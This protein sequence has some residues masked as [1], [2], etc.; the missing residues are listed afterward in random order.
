M[1]QL[2]DH[3]L[4]G[5]Q[6][7]TSAVSGSF[8]APKKYEILIAR[9]SVLELLRPDEAT[10]R[11]ISICRSEAF[12]LIRSLLP[13]RQTGSN[14]D[15][16]AIGSDS[17]KLTILQYN[18]KAARFEIIHEE[19]FGKTGVRRVVPGE[20]LAIDPLGRAL[21]IAA[22]ER[23]K[24]VYILSRDH[25]GQLAIAS[26]LDAHKSNTVTYSICAVDVGDDNPT[27]ACLEASYEQNMGLPT[28][29]NGTPLMV[30]KE[31]VL[32]ELDLGLNTVTRKLALPAD[33]GATSVHRVPAGEKGP[34]GLIVCSQSSI[35][36]ITFD[37]NNPNAQGT[38]MTCPI[39][40]RFGTPEGSASMIVASAMH[41]Q[42][43][44]LFYFFQTEFGDVFRVSLPRVRVSASGDGADAMAAPPTSSFIATDLEVKYFDTIPVSISLCILRSGFLFAASEQGPSYLF[45]LT[46]LG[47]DDETTAVLTASTVREAESK[48]LSETDAMVYFAPRPNRNLEV[49]DEVD[50]IAPTMDFKLADLAGEP[51]P[52]MYV[53]CGQAHRAQLR[54]L[55]HGVS[56]AEAS[57]T[58]LDGNPAAIFSVRDTLS[59][60]APH[61]LIAIAY[62]SSTI[63][64]RVGESVEEI[65]DSGLIA[66]ATSLLVTRIALRPS[67]IGTAAP[68]ALVQVHPQ[69]IRTVFSAGRTADWRPPGRREVIRAGSNGRQL[70]VALAG[71]ELVVF[72]ADS[73]AGTGTLTEVGTK[74][75]R[76][77]IA[78]LALAPVLPGRARGAFLV[79]GGHDSTVRVFSVLPAT[80]LKQLSVQAVAATPTSIAIVSAVQWKPSSDETKEPAGWAVSSDECHLYVGLASGVLVRS[81]LDL[82]DGKLSNS[83]RRFLGARPPK[84]VLTTLN[85]VPAVV[86]ISS[87][88]WCFYERAVVTATASASNPG[89][90]AGSSLMQLPI[91]YE[92]LDTVADFMTQVYGEGMIG[93][94]GSSLRILVPQRLGELFSQTSINLDYTPRKLL[95]VTPAN[96]QSASASDSAM[97]AGS[98]SS[99]GADASKQEPA[100]PS[101]LVLETDDDALPVAERDSLL[102]SIREVAGLTIPDGL[103]EE[104]RVQAEEAL[105]QVVR[106]SGYPRG[107]KGK[108]A[109]QLRLVDP[110]TLET[111]H[112]VALPPAGSNIHE[113]STEAAFS[114][115]Y[116]KLGSDDQGYVVV[117]TARDLIQMPKRTVSGGSIHVFKVVEE[118]P[119]G[120]DKPIRRLELVHTTE[121]NDAVLAVCGFP[122]ERMLLAAVGTGVRLYEL[123]KTKLLLKS[124][125]RG[126]PSPV[127][128]LRVSQDRVFVSTAANGIYYC[129]YSAETTFV[130]PKG[131][132][133]IA[134]GVTGENIT[135]VR[136][137]DIVAHTVAPI[138]VTSMA[139]LDHDTV[140][141]SDRFGSVFV[142]RLSAEA[143]EAIM[144]DPTRKQSRNGRVT[145]RPPKEPYKL[146]D[147]AAYYVG[148]M[149]TSLEKGVFTRGGMECI[150]YTTISGRIG[151]L[152]AMP[153]R[154]DAEL[155]LHLEMYMRK[156][157]PSLVG[158]DH[159]AFRGYYVPVCNVI[160]GALCALYTS[161]PKEVRE[162]I[163]AQ[164]QRGSAQEVTRRI[165]EI[166]QLVL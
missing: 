132:T 98:G 35:Q 42:K 134:P 17:G 124:E 55:R 23:Q 69:G 90:F 25:D 140:A 41:V 125:T 152:I 39:P 74:D 1:M 66:E 109:S 5:S 165:E 86:A 43:D 8:S 145:D 150:V 76:N 83:R 70:A 78:S 28:L 160:D 62:K 161:L 84:L 163:A 119:D 67:D 4:L 65:S 18:P 104:E 53:A 33:P 96:P 80:M 51:A 3:C 47:D 38:T 102:A 103:S 36:Y 7:I 149:V 151:T 6:T 123:G 114:T 127:C 142:V 30:K 71:G 44:M 158:R 11:L 136:R 92:P 108:W 126:F 94:V 26:P 68:G 59:S 118:K 147:V 144:N 141:V 101:L 72:E 139:V 50:S 60:S 113:G 87:R 40:Q 111:Q 162:E 10:G 2:Y 157:V 115:C 95:T 52:Q 79:V 146:M 31:I 63:V 99:A 122:K 46:S 14:R 54:V 64:L 48:G 155:C 81:Q 58:D 29:S 133:P 166:I 154:E 61:S 153:T 16:V 77:D 57:A 19:T 100:R 15:Y 143:A 27:F 75:F 22:L 164:L 91:S 156:H 45:R 120:S 20:F 21:M 85:G 32:Y 88:T 24:F 110:V 34:G 112:I 82:T 107:G 159:M 9:S 105:Q 106:F 116:A 131:P 97:K 73:S 117:G 37:L 12:G 121:V 89:P 148:E 93:T 130:G 138:Y 56:V 128:G 49:I 137:I 129:E 135:T 13:F